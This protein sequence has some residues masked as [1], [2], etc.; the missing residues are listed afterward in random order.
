MNP[1]YV[2]LLTL[3]L[4]GLTACSNDNVPK[5]DSTEAKEIVE[6]IA[7]NKSYQI[8]NFVSLKNI[9]ESGFNADSQERTC[10]ADLVTSK[11]DA[12]IYYSIT[13]ADAEHSQ[14]KVSMR[15]E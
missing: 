2:Y 9:N 1:K 6:E 7:T 12:G 10:S 8:G 11:V 15:V 3:S 13:W 14:V 4:F 5:C